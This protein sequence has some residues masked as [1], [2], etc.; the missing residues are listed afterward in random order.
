MV[1]IY[2]YEGSFWN[3]FA[4]QWV[5]LLYRYAEGC[6]NWMVKMKTFRQYVEEMSDKNNPIADLGMS[7]SPPEE[8]LV[9]IARL[10]AQNHRD[11]LMEF[12]RNLATKDHAIRHELD[13]M[14][15]NDS[16]RNLRPKGKPQ[17]SLGD[18]DEVVPH[19]A[20]GLSGVEPG[21]GQG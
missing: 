17:S 18:K 5:P 15:R 13:N 10:A 4:N 2:A 21:D 14:N 3:L 20:D 12:F 9:R 7:G 11:E 19:A 6:R 8:S 16:N 1:S